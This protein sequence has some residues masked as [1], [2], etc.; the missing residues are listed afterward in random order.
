[1]A[2][3]EKF[4]Q[5]KGKWGQ[6]K[7]TWFLEVSADIMER[8]DLILYGDHVDCGDEGDGDELTEHGEG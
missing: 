3:A 8:V 2:A 1:M 5:A 6:G 7:N 4:I